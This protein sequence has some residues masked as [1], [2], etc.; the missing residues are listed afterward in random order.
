MPC[1][2]ESKGLHLP[3]VPEAVKIGK[4]L[5]SANLVAQLAPSGDATAQTTQSTQIQK[6]NIMA[7]I[8]ATDPKMTLTS[9]RTQYV[10]STSTYRRRLSRTFVGGSPRRSGPRRN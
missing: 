10:H 6:E 7:Q 5:G 2:C 8:T 1:G 3:S 4:I 9:T